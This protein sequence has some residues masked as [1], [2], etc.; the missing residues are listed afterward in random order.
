MFSEK[1][2]PEELKRLKRWV[3]WKYESREGKPTKVPYSVGGGRADATRPESWETYTAVCNMHKMA[4]GRYNGV[5]FVFSQDDPYCGIDLD[6]CRNPETGEI[7]PWAQDIINTMGSYSEVSP[8]GTGVKIWIKG[9]KNTSR[10][11]TGYESGEIEIYD[12]GRYFTVTGNALNEP[13]IT[14][15]QTELDA[16]CKKAFGKPTLE[17][18]L[19]IVMP[20][21]SATSVI[22]DHE[23]IR[24]ARCAENGEKFKMLFDD[25]E[26][27]GYQSHSEA[28]AALMCLLAF[29]TKEKAQLERLFSKSGLVREK[30]TER[31][32][33]RENLLDGAL[34]Q[35]TDSYTPPKSIEEREAD[36]VRFHESIESV[37]E[38]IRTATSEKIRSKV[39][40]KPQFSFVTDD[41]ARSAIAG[42]ILE[43][44]VTVLESQA[45]PALPIQ[46]TLPQAV[47]LLGAVMTNDNGDGNKTGPDRLKLRILTNLNHPLSLQTYIM[48][49]APSRSGKDL[50]MVVP[51]LMKR[52]D[53]YIGTGGSAEG[54]LEAL[55][56]VGAGF[57]QIN[58]MQNF[59]NPLKWESNAEPTF[60]RLF[61]SGSF[62]ERMSKKR[63]QANFAYPSFYGQI[64]PG[65]LDAKASSRS[66]E[67]G[68]FGRFLYG[69]YSEHVFRRPNPRAIF[70]DKLL[71]VLQ[72]AAKLEGEV[73]V[74]QDYSLAIGNEAAA[75]LDAKL[76]PCAYTI[77]NMYLP[78]IA[79]MIGQRL[80]LA[81]TSG[82][83]PEEAEQIRNI[84]QRAEVIA[85]WFV[86]NAQTAIGGIGLGDGSSSSERL[87][88]LQ[89]MIKEGIRLVM[90]WTEKNHPTISRIR[91]T[92][93]KFNSIRPAEFDEALQVLI[94]SGEV[95]QVGSGNGTY[96]VLA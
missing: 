14:E 34:G 38:T 19:S 7:T 33:Y 92:T 21:E 91:K 1:N 9:K 86:G 22:S 13:T 82:T 79:V 8:S 12:N 50:G 43:E 5:G 81:I 3:L 48:L 25:G 55:A 16:L 94:D 93:R 78:K 72:T 18:K 85:R 87:V 65:I 37:R 44:I 29:Y 67:S 73:Q 49:V 47:A 28:D 39:K 56:E 64:Q 58:E 42:T 90:G 35:V 45:V 17:P 96:F 89:R 71:P 61:E 66:I 31:A 63:R 76:I 59:L 30:W 40:G 69:C 95:E 51:R 68:L 52:F 2:V 41:D 53:K 70:A 60:N 46:I 88:E 36:E 6:D 54:I 57:L 77:A 84:W 4:N 10:C 32:D 80:Q 15:R 75:T 83:N 11:R 62:D 24:L 23:I 27:S 26:T 20:E 74:P